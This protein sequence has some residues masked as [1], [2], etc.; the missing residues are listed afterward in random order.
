MSPPW[1]QRLST[2]SAHDA[3]RRVPVIILIF[4]VS[5]S[6]IFVFRDSI[7]PL[8]INTPLPEFS[9]VDEQKSIPADVQECRNRPQKDQPPTLDELRNMVSQT[10]GYFG[11]DWSV[12]LGWNNVRCPDE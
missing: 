6:L 9:R 5:F 4:V 10:N 11:R 1:I 7:H 12:H 2:T 3:R 8:S